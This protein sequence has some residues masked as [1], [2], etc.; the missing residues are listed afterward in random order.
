M[1]IYHNN[2]V[3]IAGNVV[4]LLI[5]V[6]SSMNFMLYSAMSTKFRRVF[7]RMFCYCDRNGIDHF[8]KTELS[9]YKGQ[10]M[11]SDHIV[12]QREKRKMAYTHISIEQEEIITL[13]IDTT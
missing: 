3:R 6:N 11:R 12:L 10:S 1:S 7:M 5:L 9:F 13:V 2:A 4:N 8:S